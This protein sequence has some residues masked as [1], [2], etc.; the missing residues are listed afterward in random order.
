MRRRVLAAAAVA[1]AVAAG[2]AAGSG[3]SPA[4]GGACSLLTRAEAEAV[5]KV[6]LQPGQDGGSLCTY[7]GYPTGPTAQLTIV[8]QDTIPRTLQLDRKL[9]HKFVKVKGLGDEAYEEDWNVFARKGGV[10]VALNVVRTD[11]WA[12]YRA[13][14]EHATAIA[15]ARASKGAGSS[16]GSGGSTGGSGGSGSTGAAPG[17]AA[18]VGHLPAGGGANP[19]WKGSQRRFGGS[20]TTYKG[21]TYQPNVVVIGGGASAVRGESPDGLTWTLAGGAPGIADLK[22]GKIMLATTF[23]SGRV[24]ALQQDG[25]NVKV[26]L[27]PVSLTDVVR[28]GTFSS[29]GPIAIKQPLFYNNPL[30]AP[31]GHSRRPQSVT[32]AADGAGT[33]TTTPICCTNAGIH[34]GYDSPAGR[35][36]TTVQLQLDKPTVDFSIRIGGGKLLETSF[37]LKGA[38]ALDYEIEGATKNVSGNVRSGPIALPGSITIPLGVGP[39]SLTLTQAFDVSMQLSGAAVLK[40]SGEYKLTGALGFSAGGGGARGDAVAMATKKSIIEHT[41]G[42]GYGT[43][44]LSLGWKLKATVGIGGGGFTAGAWYAIVPGLALAMDVSPGSLKWGCV[45][46][47]ISVS[48][49][50]GVGYT[51]PTYV[52]KVVNAILRVLNVK[53]ISVSGGPSWG[54]YPIWN[55]PRGEECPKPP[56]K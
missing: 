19:R 16:G 22:V 36:S 52:A 34:I 10:W 39:L 2:T 13:A 23:A 50:F 8:V 29:N 56:G 14:T 15:L 42:V 27:G 1:L 7:N 35:M 54:P 12:N 43:N 18:V 46:A 31:A 45:T 25:P 5:V 53:P 26:T 44:A 20:V 41:A 30:T 55:P 28:D 37:Q 47:A 6:K 3:A 21:V 33:F 38:G 32:R 40:A 48:H 51:I 9:H 49:E 17:Q 4:A 11:E 24:L